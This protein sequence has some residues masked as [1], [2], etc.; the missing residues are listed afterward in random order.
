MRNLRKKDTLAERVPIQTNG[1]LK[2][3]DKNRSEHKLTGNVD[4]LSF[5]SLQP[6]L[7]AN[8]RPRQK[9][10]NGE[11]HVNINMYTKCSKCSDHETNTPNNA[12]LIEGDRGNTFQIYFI[13]V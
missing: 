3:H 11:D 7:R 4:P 8:L 9:E 2:C 13:F 5:G 6:K 12:E 1:S 10:A